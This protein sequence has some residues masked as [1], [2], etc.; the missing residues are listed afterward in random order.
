MDGR[1]SI[2]GGYRASLLPRP[3][4]FQPLDRRVFTGRTFAAPPNRTDRRRST[5]YN[6][7][8]LQH[9]ISRPRGRVTAPSFTNVRR[10]L[11]IQ[12]HPLRRPKFRP[13]APV[14]RSAVSTR[15]C[16]KKTA[17]LRPSRRPTSILANEVIIFVLERDQPHYRSSRPQRRYRTRAAGIAGR[18]RVHLVRGRDALGCKLIWRLHY[19]DSRSDSLVAASGAPMKFRCT[20]TPSRRRS[21]SLRASLAFSYSPAHPII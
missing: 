1:S 6:L 14:H 10:F 4:V 17:G 3:P 16:W 7:P 15:C 9:E 2:P 8:A 11:R 19:T 12:L 21:A 13:I 20:N 5:S 18:S